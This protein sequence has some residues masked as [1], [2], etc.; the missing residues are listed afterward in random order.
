MSASENT[1]TSSST[2]L[3]YGSEDSSPEKTIRRPRS[4]ESNEIEGIKSKNGLW[5]SAAPAPKSNPPKKMTMP[6]APP[7]APQGAIK[8]I[9][10]NKALVEKLR[11]TDSYRKVG[12]VIPDDEKN[13]EDLNSSNE[14]ESEEALENADRDSEESGAEIEDEDYIKNP[15]LPV[16]RAETSLAEELH[17]DAGDEEEMN[18]L[19]EEVRKSGFLSHRA[20]KQLAQER[21]TKILNSSGQ[22]QQNS[23]IDSDEKPYDKNQ[24]D[25]LKSDKNGEKILH[26]F[27]GGAFDVPEPII[28]RNNFFERSGLYNK[29]GREIIGRPAKKIQHSFSIV[30][31]EHGFMPMSARSAYKGPVCNNGTQPSA[32]TG[33]SEDGE[34]F[35]TDKVYCTILRDRFTSKMYPEYQLILD[36]TQKPLLLAKKMKLNKT[37]NYHIFDTS[38]GRVAMK[39]GAEFDKKSGNYL[40]KLRARSMNGTDYVLY[41]NENSSSSTESNT[42]NF[43]PKGGSAPNDADVLREL[44]AIS[45]EK[46][47]ILSQFT[48]GSQPRKLTVL[49]PPLDADGV[50]VANTYLRNDAA[51]HSL[52][53]ILK[54]PVEAS[55]RECYLLE[56]KEPTYENGNYRLNFSGRVTMPSVKNFQLVSPDDKNNIL[57]QFGKIGDDTFHLDFKRPITAFQAF[58]FA[59]SQFNM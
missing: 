51:T 56:N 3:D 43:L 1:K 46:L 28:A 30:A 11:T 50:P 26:V 2:Y 48:S 20:L 4:V 15:R 39:G 32:R 36:S 19:N 21:G 13:Q 16:P 8:S 55:A 49:V 27:H 12:V 59:L 44:G 23:K 41:G 10:N 5:N 40:G 53:S 29:D 18:E 47:N 42:N 31:H 38:R 57:C 37:S 54:D 33:A 22:S 58:A 17:N 6:K 25:I 34:Y 52:Q 45:Y 35:E 7:G 9:L 14:Q 24:M